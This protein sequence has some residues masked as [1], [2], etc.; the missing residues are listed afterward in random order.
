M[1]KGIGASAGIGIGTAVLVK[2]ANLDYSHVVSAGAE[3]EKA[4]LSGAVADFIQKTRAMAEA[5]KEKVGEH[6]AEILLGQVMM[7]EDPYM[8]GQ[9]N[10]MIDMGQC[11]EAAADAVCQMY[12][13]MFS[14]MDDEMMRQR[15]TDIKDMRDRLLKLLLNQPDL[16]LSL[17]PPTAVL[18][19]RVKEEKK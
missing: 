11:A 7:I 3:A 8:T 14:A 19:Y 13:A 1:F 2:E 15:A 5:M 10:E 17:L 6:Q 9:M 12:I 18:V 16:D 4:R